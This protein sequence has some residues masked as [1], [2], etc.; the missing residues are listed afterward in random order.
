MEM[1]TNHNNTNTKWFQ[2][3]LDDVS[4]LVTIDGLREVTILTADQVLQVMA[5]GEK[6]RHF[7]E[8]QMN[9][10]SSR[11]HTIFRII[12]ES[13]D[14]EPGIEANEENGRAIMVSHLNLVDLAG[15]ERAA[16][17]GAVGDRFKEGANINNSLMVLGQVNWYHFW[18]GG[19]HT[20]YGDFGFKSWR[21]S[22]Y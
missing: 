16:Q 18:L 8:T 4:G 3:V 2:Q 7:G 9:E 20:I 21:K 19:D 15:S 13:S 5:E 12:I 22:A 14:N 17:T 10:R 6:Y 11:S 1:H